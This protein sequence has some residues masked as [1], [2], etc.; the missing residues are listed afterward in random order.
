[1]MQKIEYNKNRWFEYERKLFERDSDSGEE[2]YVITVKT[3]S[4]FPEKAVFD[5]IGKFPIA[6][7]N[8]FDDGY[9][10]TYSEVVK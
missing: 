9:F 7:S 3:S 6:E 1:M 10:Y 4:L 2:Y 5:S 8:V